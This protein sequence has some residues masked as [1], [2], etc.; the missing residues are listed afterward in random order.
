[1]S[2]THD[3]GMGSFKN[4]LWIANKNVFTK[5]SDVNVEFL[6]GG[7][8]DWVIADSAG[9]VLKT[10]RHSGPTGWTSLNFPSLGLYGNYS[11]GFRN[12]SPGE[13]KIRGGDVT[14]D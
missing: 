2:R 7:D 1:M 6:T 10:I 5:P 12:A 11:I 4:E 14:Y 9:T 13:K 3:F 8:W